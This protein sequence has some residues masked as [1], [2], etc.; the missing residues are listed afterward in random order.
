MIEA[1]MKIK[2]DELNLLRIRL[3]KGDSIVSEVPLSAIE[4]FL[5]PI[6]DRSF[7]DHLTALAKGLRYFGNKDK[8]ADGKVST[9]A[10]VEFVIPITS[11]D[12]FIAA[13][14]VT[15]RPD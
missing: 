6:N 3:K 13:K 2:L 4:T 11:L 1:A 9:E 12:A 7:C 10:S 15:T 8:A 5:E 14:A